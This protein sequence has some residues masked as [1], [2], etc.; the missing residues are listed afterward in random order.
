MFRGASIAADLSELV[1]NSRLLVLATPIIRLFKRA[2]AEV[3]K[4]LADKDAKNLQA[5][6]DEAKENRDRLSA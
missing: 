3:E 2:L 4:V 1:S 5:L 6:L